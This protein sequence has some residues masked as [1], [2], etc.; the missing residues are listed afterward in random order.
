[1][2]KYHFTRKIIRCYVVA[3][4]NVLG[5]KTLGR[6]R[7]KTIYLTYKNIFYVTA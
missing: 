1:M 3:Q 2:L 6:V 7:A 4:Y 5:G